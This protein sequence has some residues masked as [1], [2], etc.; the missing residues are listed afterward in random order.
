MINPPNIEGHFSHLVVKT[1]GVKG[2]LME[3]MNLNNTIVCKVKGL[4]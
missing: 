1:K 2:N 3:W 4:V